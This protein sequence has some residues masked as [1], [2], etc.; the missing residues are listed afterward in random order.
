MADWLKELEDQK[1]KQNKGG[2][3]TIPTLV[4]AN[5]GGSAALQL[6]TTNKGTAGNQYR[7]ILDS[8]KADIW[9]K[10]EPAINIGDIGNGLTG[11]ITPIAAIPESVTGVK[12]LSQNFTPTY[13]QGARNVSNYDKLNNNSANGGG[14][15]KGNTGG[16]SGGGSNN[17]GLMADYKANLDDLYNKVMGYGG[18]SYSAYTPSV[19]NRTVDTSATEAALKAALGDIQNY[20][21]FSYDLNADMLYQNA[22]DNYMMLGQ[23]AMV[24]TTANAAA[25]TGGYG[26]SYAASVGNQAYQ[27]YITQAN[28]MIPQFQQ[29][30]LN[31]WQSGLDR[32]MGVYDA[33]S[34]QLANELSIEDMAFAIWAQNEA[35]A[36][37]AHS[38]NSQGAY[39]EWSSGLDQLMG[40][41]EM[42]KDYYA[43]LEAL[44][45]AS[46]G[47]GGSSS[48]GN[49]SSSANKTPATTGN[50]VVLPNGKVVNTTPAVTNPYT[51]AQLEELLKLQNKK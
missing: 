44:Q 12:E 9:N 31:T 22:L 4:G 5:S 30:A 6:P 17:S 25:L 16:G 28:N 51:S 3:I 18:Y 8:N 48:S 19:Y 39:N 37:N 27:N 35:N 20:G 13:V 41:Y 45:K 40:Q 10:D 42:A 34:Q 32:R 15:P 36:A 24:D 2:Y 50:Q 43:T 1:K 26:N 7:G 38:M 14:K 46:G 47:S 23:Q 11:F 33:V 49:K 21:D 29:M